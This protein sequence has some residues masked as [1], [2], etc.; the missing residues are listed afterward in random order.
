M[1]LYGVYI[2]VRGR[3]GAVGDEK[4]GVKAGREEEERDENGRA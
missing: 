2:A 3:A 1:G 4:A